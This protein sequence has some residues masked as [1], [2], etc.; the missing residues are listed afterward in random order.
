MDIINRKNLHDCRSKHVWDNDDYG[1]AKPVYDALIR[2]FYDM[3]VP[4]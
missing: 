4:E 2:A 1:L 3:N